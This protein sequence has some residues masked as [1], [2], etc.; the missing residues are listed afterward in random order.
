ME[1]MEY[2]IGGKKSADK[3]KWY[4]IQKTFKDSNFTIQLTRMEIGQIDFKP[5]EYWGISY[6]PLFTPLRA[7]EIPDKKEL[8]TQAGVVNERVGMIAV[9]DAEVKGPVK[10]RKLFY[11]PWSGEW[12]EAKPWVDDFKRIFWKEQVKDPMKPTSKK[13]LLALL[14][15]LIKKR[16]LDGDFNDIDTSQ[17]TI[18]SYLFSDFPGFNGDITKW[19]VS[20][21]RYMIGMFSGCT[22]FNQDI[23]GWNVG[24]VE[25]VSEGWDDGMFKDC[26][27]F[28]QDLEPW[29]KWW[30][31][32]PP[33]DASVIF[34]GCTS[35]KKIPHWCK[36]PLI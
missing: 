24:K 18:M 26:K 16:G 30:A 36:D 13:E 17:V 27:S 8:L 15:K 10:F 1:L 32:N 28:N 34:K 6:T 5:E 20:N 7:L 2:L 21:V 31:K 23:S 4:I 35:L 29:G 14:K 11:E 3:S 33:D 12:V 9:C 25:F 19:D 22:R